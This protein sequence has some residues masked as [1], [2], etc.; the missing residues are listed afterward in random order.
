[1]ILPN[2]RHL[3]DMP[4]EIAYL[5]CA[6]MSPLL[7]AARDAGQA[8]VARKSQPWGIAAP[9]FFEESETAR[10]LFAELIGADAEGVALI[11][12]A[13]YGVSL[14]AANL[15]IRAGQR[16]VVL[17]E[18][19]PSNVYPWRDLAARSEAEVVTVPRPADYDWTSAI[20]DRIDEWT[21]IVAVPQCHWTDGS[22][23][24]LVRVGERARA[25][26]AALVVD[27]TQS[28][29]ASPLDVTQVRPD[30]LIA[31]GYKWLLGPYSSGF[32]YAAPARREGRPLEFNWI[33]R[34]G[35]EDFAGLVLYRDTFQPGAR[36]Y[37]V[38]ERSNFAL[39]PIAIVALRQ[40]LAWRVAE[41]A[42]TLG[43]LTGAVEARARDLG[44]HPVPAAWRVGH[45]LGLRSP[46]PLP[47]DLPTRLAAANV[48]VSVRG[49]SIRISPHLYNTPEDIERLFATLAGVL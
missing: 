1:M 24:D 34:E 20:L 5:N 37:D 10:G 31:A 15:P 30:F 22:L 42:T 49:Q 13:S 4:D 7:N 27:A 25:A 26:G 23:I 38:G 17:A 32:V 9:D 48:F 45:M 16:I 46:A 11:P 12:A 35:S 14:A 21:A 19:F 36:R 44:L 33:A 47:A 29:G 18:E 43:A 2:Q 40:L 28:L 8:A 3:F 39:L 41:I 6:Y